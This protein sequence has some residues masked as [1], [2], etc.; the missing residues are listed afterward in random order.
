MNL[1]FSTN[2]S[3]STIIKG[4]PIEIDFSI[5]A[6]DVEKIA[7]ARPYRVDLLCL[8]VSDRAGLVGWLCYKYYGHFF[9]LF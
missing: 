7:I 4:L 3:R 1:T 2:K 9:I 8:Y 6:E 5:I